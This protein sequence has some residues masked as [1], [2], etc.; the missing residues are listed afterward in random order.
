MPRDK[1][2]AYPTQPDASR[3]PP[4]R[5]SAKADD[6]QIREIGRFRAAEHH[7]TIGV[8]QLLHA[9][10]DGLP[11]GGAHVDQDVSQQHQIRDGQLRPGVLE[12]DALEANHLAQAVVDAPRTS[13]A[14]EVLGQP[15]VG[16]AAADFHV[17]V[18]AGL[19]LLQGRSRQVG[20]QQ[21]DVPIAQ[22]LGE[23]FAQND[24]DAVGFLARGAAARSPVSL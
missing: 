22:L 24:C 11:G 13:L 7:A 20:G 15:C 23:V 18:A 12:I 6:L 16:Q 5:P 8:Q 1:R 14:A 9:G 3:G 21:V 4:L 10:E 19:G 2:D 17:G